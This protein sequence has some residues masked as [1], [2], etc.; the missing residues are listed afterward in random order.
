MFS[1]R[2]RAALLG[3]LVCTLAACTTSQPDES[4]EPD[5]G[6]PVQGAAGIG[7]P[8]YPEDGNGGYDATGYDVSIGYNPDN[9]NLD[10]DTTV[11]ARATQDLER[12]NLDLRGF[13]VSSVEVDG[14]P[15]EFAREGDFELVITP[16]EPLA[17]GSEFTTRVRYDGKP[18]DASSAQLGGNGWQR[19]ESG[20]AF[21]LGEPQSG[22]YWYP[23]NEHPRDKATFRLTARVPQGWTAV[24]IGTQESS[25]TENGW[26]TS[27][28]TEQEPVASYLTT[29]AVD[30][31]T[32]DKGQLA[33][34]TPVLSAYA[35]GAEGIRR[36][37]DR[38]GEVIDFLT[39]KFGEYPATSAGGIYLANDVGYSLETQGRPTYT[40]GA[41]FSTIVHELAHQ[42]YGNE[43][44]VE[45]WADI[46]LNE[47]LASYSEWLW[48]EGKQ[49]DNLDA[50]YRNNIDQ[51]RDDTEFWGQKLYDMGAGNEFEGVY[52][53]GTLAIH[54]L[55][56]QIGDE[57]FDRVLKQWPV[58]HREGNASWPDFEQFVSDVSGQDLEGFFA[59][60]F[61]GTELPG[62]EHLYPGS[63]RN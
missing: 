11:T 4:R 14:Q 18:Q 8:Y 20:G 33:D 1:R 60:W 57:A 30:R 19:S 59:D 9:G 31:F 46:C 48:A 51:L 17:E 36:D 41:D 34:G 55:R 16:G 3:G 28:W 39:T 27:T 2:A 56:K 62:D 32:V 29:V 50:R 15:A 5:Q 54:A 61:R 37:A 52:D 6:A 44:S 13:T 53:K 22:S 63:L 43:V 42:W 25:K 40:L 23:V 26:T 47:C 24:S 12:F 21:V 10:G 35:P 38:V 58:E 49:G 45:S 7:D